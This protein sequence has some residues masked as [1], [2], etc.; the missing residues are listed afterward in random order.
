MVRNADIN[1]C[2]EDSHNCSEYADC[3]NTYG[4]FNCKCYEGYDGD[5]VLCES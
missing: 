3:K 5:G 2:L 4:G 1:E